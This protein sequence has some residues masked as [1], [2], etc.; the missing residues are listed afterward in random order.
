MK[1]SIYSCERERT[2]RINCTTCEA[3]YMRMKRNGSYYQKNIASNPTTFDINDSGC[4]V[5]NS[6]KPGNN[7]YLD[8]RIRGKR[9]SLHRYMYEECFGFIPEGMMV[10]HKCDNRQCINPEHL[11]LGTHQDN[12]RDMVERGRSMKGKGSRMSKKNLTKEDV[13]KI[14]FLLGAGLKQGDIAKKFNIH[15]ESV[16]FINRGK[17]WKNVTLTAEY[18]ADQYFQGKCETN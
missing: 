5:V 16:S 13:M 17:T 9:V 14:K 18:L 4:F 6:I 11:E 12:M 8:T 10:R 7:G 1:C 2:K 3:C 15:K